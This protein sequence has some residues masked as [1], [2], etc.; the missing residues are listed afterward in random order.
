MDG[1]LGIGL[2]PKIIEKLINMR[3]KAKV[4]MSKSSGIDK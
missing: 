4:L 1:T 3:K 2:L